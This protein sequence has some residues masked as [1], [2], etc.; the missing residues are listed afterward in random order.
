MKMGANV[1]FVQVRDARSQ[2][3]TYSLLIDRSADADS[4]RTKSAY[5]RSDEI[6]YIGGFAY[7]R[8]REASAELLSLVTTV[9]QLTPRFNPA[10]RAYTISVDFHV[11][12]I[13][14]TAKPKDKEA[15]LSL[16]HS[17]SLSSS[18]APALLPLNRDEASEVIPLCV[19]E[20]TLKVQVQ[21][22]D[23]VVFDS[24]VIVITR[25]SEADENDGTT[26]ELYPQE[27]PAGRAAPVTPHR[28]RAAPSKHADPTLLGLRGQSYDVH[29]EA[30]QVYNLI[31]EPHLLVNARFVN[32]AALNS[33]AAPAGD[34]EPIIGIGEIAVVTRT[35]H[36]LHL[37]TGT[38]EPGT[39][40]GFSRVALN[41]QVMNVEDQ[42]FIDNSAESVHEESDTA[43]GAGSSHA[44]LLA[45]NAS[46]TFTVITPHWY[47]VFID[48]REGIEPRA[49]ITSPLEIGA[50]G[51]LGQTWREKREG[52]LH[53]HD[54]RPMGRGGIGLSTEGAEDSMDIL[55][56]SMQD[57]RIRDG[58]LFSANFEF[59]LFE[60]EGAT[61]DTSQSD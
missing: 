48:T 31:T 50:H 11:P 1:L 58:A 6:E 54:D 27:G 25:A 2:V 35:G 15:R 7:I 41:E 53:S 19:G 42:A 52:R 38:G 51:L 37:E 26:A 22:Y 56:G 20:T 57:Y 32:M 9:G 13:Q 44:E 59:N 40:T 3:A 12:A 34:L 61:V 39:R 33:D 24:Y 5:E 47:I 21:S 17:S 16:L 30:G 45:Y 28:P 43:D 55:E 18:P 14:L 8:I 10:V 60:R 23:S 36:Q 29:V 49:R 46:A 4:A